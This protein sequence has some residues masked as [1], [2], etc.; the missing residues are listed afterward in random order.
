[1]AAY[2]DPRI[3]EDSVAADQRRDVPYYENL[4]GTVISGGATGVLAW[5]NSNRKAWGRKD[6]DGDLYYELE[7]TASG[8]ITVRHATEL[9][10]DTTTVV[11]SLSPSTS[12]ITL[13][14]GVTVPLHSSL[15]VELASTPSRDGQ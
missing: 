15:T 14:P 6:A 5:A 10:D 8:Q 11:S 7:V 1:M 3:Y 2:E 13:V 12:Y 4:V 9:G